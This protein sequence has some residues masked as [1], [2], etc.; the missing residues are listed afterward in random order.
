MIRGLGFK[1]FGFQRGRPASEQFGAAVIRSLGSLIP[2]GSSDGQ[3]A[4]DY[5]AVPV[6]H[7]YT[8]TFGS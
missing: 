4:M 3:T 5:G 6:T 7:P 2:P 1:G 8:C